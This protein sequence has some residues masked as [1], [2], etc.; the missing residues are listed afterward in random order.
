M[1][2]AITSE[3][4]PRLLL[5]SLS[6]FLRKILQLTSNMTIPLTINMTV[7]PIKLLKLTRSVVMACSMPAL[8]AMLISSTF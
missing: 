5:T 6:Y 8:E 7:L 2:L 3:I 4:I 1:Y